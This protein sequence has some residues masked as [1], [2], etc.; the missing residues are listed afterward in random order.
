MTPCP[1]CGAIR[2]G[3]HT[4]TCSSPEARMAPPREPPPGDEL[5]EVAQRL[6]RMDLCGAHTPR[7]HFVTLGRAASLLEAAARGRPEGL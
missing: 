5:R 4:D 2:P 7:A 6:R 1:E 3:G